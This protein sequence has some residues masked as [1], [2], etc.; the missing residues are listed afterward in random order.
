MTKC[1]TSPHFVHCHLYINIF[2]LCIQTK[3][4]CFWV[5]KVFFWL[6]KN[7]NK[8]NIKLIANNKPSKLKQPPTISKQ[9]SSPTLVVPATPNI[10]PL[11]PPKPF[12][13]APLKALTANTYTENA[14][15]TKV[16]KWANC[17]KQPNQQSQKKKKKNSIQFEITFISVFECFYSFSPPACRHILWE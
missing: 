2:V 10:Q 1:T 8:K 9:V 16:N 5:Y 17:I 7:N 14:T 11:S 15:T 12:P 4:T 6:K 13:I 3:Y